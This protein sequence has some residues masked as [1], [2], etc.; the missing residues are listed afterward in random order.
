MDGSSLLPNLGTVDF[1]YNKLSVVPEFLDR[2]INLEMLQL[3][4]ND[5]KRFP[6]KPSSFGNALQHINLANNKL[7]NMPERMQGLSDLRYVQI[8]K[9]T[10]TTSCRPTGFVVCC[11]LLCIHRSLLVRG[12]W[13]TCFPEDM[14]DLLEAVEVGVA[15]HTLLHL[16]WCV[17]SQ[18]EREREGEGEEE[19]AA[20]SFTSSSFPLFGTHVQA[21]DGSNNDVTHLPENI[22]KMKSLT[23]LDMHH[24]KLAALPIGLARLHKLQVLNLRGNQITAVPREFGVLTAIVSLDLSKN[25]LDTIPFEIGYLSSLVNLDL[26]HNN[27]ISLPNSV[28][29]SDVSVLPCFVLLTY[30][31]LCCVND[32]T[33]APS[34]FFL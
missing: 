3:Q 11:H 29:Y 23:N 1:S 17:F 15:T 10:N 4:S 31:V 5:I 32:D 6:L 26:G 8:L 16:T 24:N 21:L 33:A 9:N 27:L 22:Q 25:A 7:R 19:R 2:L 28:R 34:F 13:L 30:A 18:R 14:I 12:N 20:F